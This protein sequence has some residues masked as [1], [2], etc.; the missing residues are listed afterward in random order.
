MPPSLDLYKSFNNSTLHLKKVA[1]PHLRMGHFTQFQG[2]MAQR[3]RF[4]PIFGE[5]ASRRIG[6]TG[7][8]FSGSIACSHRKRL[9]ISRSASERQSPRQR[10]SS[11]SRCR[12]EFPK[13]NNRRI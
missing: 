2:R 6:R 11:G 5:T 10:W 13:N 12:G 9:Q 1:N 4:F 8:D 7:L 3:R